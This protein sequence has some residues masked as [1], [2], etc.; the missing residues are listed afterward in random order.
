MTCLRRILA[1]MIDPGRMAEVR[2]LRDAIVLAEQRR[3]RAEA[4]RAAAVVD[5][6]I[7]AGVARREIEHLRADVTRLLEAAQAC[8]HEHDNS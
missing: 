3:Q 1:D 6:A 2:H 4:D 5:H 8:A 7:T